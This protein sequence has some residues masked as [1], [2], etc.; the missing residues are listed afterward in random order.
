[1][2]RRNKLISDQLLK[3]NTLLWAL[4]RVPEGGPV[5]PVLRDAGYHLAAIGRPIAVPED[6]TVMRAL[7]R[8]NGYES[9]SPYRTDLWLQHSSDRVQLI[10]ELQAHSSPPDASARRQARKLLV[11]AF[12][13]STLSAGT[14]ERRGHVIYAAEASYARQTASTLKELAS[15]L[16]AESAPTA[17]A[18]VVGLAE[19]G[20]GV[21]L[22]SPVPGDLPGPAARS[23]SS[24]ATVLHREGRNDPRPL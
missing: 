19:D 2:A 21:H 9:R 18:G 3:L 10:V 15:E 11:S 13:L 7:V 1:M 22:M 23:L 17:P 5:E 12:D 4:Q 6:R 24:P 8:L 14:R 20:A 16:Q